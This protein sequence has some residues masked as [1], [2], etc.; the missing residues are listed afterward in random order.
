MQGAGEI[1]CSSAH[2]CKAASSFSARILH[3]VFSELRDGERHDNPKG[4]LLYLPRGS[5]R[6]SPQHTFG[7]LGRHDLAGNDS[8]S[9][10]DHSCFASLRKRGL[11]PLSPLR[12]YLLRTCRRR[13]MQRHR[14]ATTRIL[15]CIPL[16][17]SLTF[18][19]AISRD[20]WDTSIW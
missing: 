3:V 13:T 9:N 11:H 2:R 17:I 10:W 19:Y 5:I 16:T 12:V 4:A 6:A 1:S 18:S 7:M 15:Q 14:T 20:S 8:G